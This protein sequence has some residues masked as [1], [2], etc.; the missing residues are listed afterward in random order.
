MQTRWD[1]KRSLL[2]AHGHLGHLG[3]EVV[4]AERVVAEVNGAREPGVDDRD[5]GEDA[6]GICRDRERV[7][8]CPAVGYGVSST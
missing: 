5:H 6:T 4:P 8:V 2:E 3:H 1:P 7:V